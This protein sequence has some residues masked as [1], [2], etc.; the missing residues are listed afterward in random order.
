MAY[1]N[2]NTKGYKQ[3][4]GYSTIPAPNV[5]VAA[6]TYVVCTRA[7]TYSFSYPDGT[8]STLTSSMIP[9]AEVVAADVAKIKFVYKGGLDGLGRP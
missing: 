3:L 7:G 1:N 5:K 6:P 8:E 2:Y 9:G 4:A